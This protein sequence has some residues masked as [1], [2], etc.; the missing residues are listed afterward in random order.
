[1]TTRDNVLFCGHFFIL[2]VSKSMIDGY[3]LFEDINLTDL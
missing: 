2:L 3:L 1:M